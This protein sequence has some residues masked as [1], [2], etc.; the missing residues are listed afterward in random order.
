MFDY[1]FACQLWYWF[2]WLINI[3]PQISSLETC[4]NIINICLDLRTVKLISAAIIHIINVIK[5]AKNNSKF[6]DIKTSWSACRASII[7]NMTSSTFPIISSILMMKFSIN[8]VLSIKLHSL[9][10]FLLADV[11]WQPLFLDGSKEI[12][13]A[14][15][16]GLLL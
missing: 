11:L 15:L 14:W 12:H 1:P 7:Y 6:S 3:H 13:M 9:D 2:A 5:L 10:P 4:W 8:K 16:L